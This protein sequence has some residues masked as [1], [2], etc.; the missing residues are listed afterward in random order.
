MMTKGIVY[1]MINPCLDGWVKIGFTEK[2]STEERLKELN[3]PA[4]IPLSFRVWAE[5]YTDNPRETEQIIHNIIN[6]VDESCRAVE[7][8]DSGRKRIREF[9][10]IS[11]EKAYELFKNIA[12]LR[13]DVDSL[14]LIEPTQV[15]LD[16]DEIANRRR[17]RFKFSMVG[18]SP[19]TELTFIKDEETTCVTNDEE[20][21]VVYGG[22][23]YTLSGLASKLLTE[24]CGWKTTSTVQG[25]LYFRYNGEALSDM[26]IRL[27]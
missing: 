19:G 6:C 18:L 22:K 21:H 7:T 10:Q 20:N 17:P 2:N 26:R 8:K 27:E 3:T 25:P 14:N 11:P 16:E 12:K 24:K 15:E 13:G 4:N 9:F 5:Y 23:I 1:I